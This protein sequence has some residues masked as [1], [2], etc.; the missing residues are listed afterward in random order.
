MHNFILDLLTE[1][2]TVDFGTAFIFPIVEL[3]YLFLDEEESFDF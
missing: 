1:D 3:T 2:V